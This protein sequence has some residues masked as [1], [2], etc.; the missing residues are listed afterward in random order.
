MNVGK[1]VKE[2][3]I[4]QQFGLHKIMAMRLTTHSYSYFLTKVVMSHDMNDRS[5]F[6]N[7]INVYVP[8]FPKKTTIC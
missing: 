6:H 2:N 1:N 7:S 8:R 5:R 4:V 3:E